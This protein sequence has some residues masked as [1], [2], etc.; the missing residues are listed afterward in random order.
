MMGRRAVMLMWLIAGCFA[1]H[2]ELGG[3]CADNGECPS[4]QMCSNDVCVAIGT[5]IDASISDA[6]PDASPADV[7]VPL[8]A[9]PFAIR[10]DLDGPMYDGSDYPGTWQADPGVGG[11]C[12]GN[13]NA[14]PTPTVNGTND[15]TLFIGQMYAPTLTCEVTEVPPGTYAVTLLF[16]EL[17]IGGKPCKQAGGTDRVFDIALEGTTVASAFDMTATGSGCAATGGPGHAFAE[18]YTI[19]VTDGTLDVVET[20]ALGNAALNAIELVQQ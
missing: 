10:I 17:R 1:P 12:N 2:A 15:S 11:I 13:S 7:A 6:A 4:G 18:T 20:S 16:A 14:S 9:P 3:R 19:A 5:A 8:D